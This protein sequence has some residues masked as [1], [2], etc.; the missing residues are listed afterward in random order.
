MTRVIDMGI[1]IKPEDQ[2]KLFQS[3]LQLDTGLSRQQQGRGLGLSICKKLVA[4]LGGNIRVESK[5]G[6]GAAFTF[7]LPP[8]GGD[9]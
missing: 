9:S 8:N 2:Q 5:P 3:F 4:L 7:T 1:G 6:E